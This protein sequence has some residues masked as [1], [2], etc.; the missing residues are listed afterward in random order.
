MLV[1]GARGRAASDGAPRPTAL[2]G[3]ADGKNLAIDW[4]GYGLRAEQFDEHAAELVKAEV[5]VILAGGD[6]AVRAAQRATTQIPILALTDDMLGEGFVRSLA[7][8]GGNTTGVTIIASE[9]D[10]KRQEIL[11]EMVP[12]ARRLGA[13]VDTNMATAPHLRALESAACARSR[14]IGPFGCAA[15]GNLRSNRR[16]AR[17]RRQGA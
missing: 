4:R 14:I 16:S 8:P 17:S 5:D 15:G 2:A 7:E 10:G 13:L 9:L 3:F 6:A 12:T 11:I 1:C